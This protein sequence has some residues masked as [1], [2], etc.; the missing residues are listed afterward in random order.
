M[1]T[2]QP[3][4]TSRK[5]AAVGPINTTVPPRMTPEQVKALA[6]GGDQFIYLDVRTTTEFLDGHPPDAWNIP[7][8]LVDPATSGMVMNGEFLS[9]VE[10]NI[11][12]ETRVIVGCRSGRRSAKA[13]TLME[14]AGYTRVS[15]MLGGFVGG[16]DSSTGAAVAGWSRSG[17][18]IQRGD[19]DEHG[20]AALAAKVKP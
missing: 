6:D 12:K 9:V 13:Q 5:K 14:A 19:G 4:A 18:P 8:A 15:N 1:T 16:N 3:E 10:A 2:D 20:Y 7:V 11:P 17:Y